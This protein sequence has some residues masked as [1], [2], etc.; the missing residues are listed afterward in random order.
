MRRRAIDD[1]GPNTQILREFGDRTDP[2][3]PGRCAGTRPRTARPIGSAPEVAARIR[4]HP[5]RV[6]QRGKCL[7]GLQIG[8]IAG[9]LTMTGAMSSSTPF[10]AASSSSGAVPAPPTVNHSEVAPF[11]RSST[12]DAAAAAGS[13]S[14]IG[15]RMSHPDSDRTMARPAGTAAS[16]R[17]STRRAADRSGVPSGGMDR[18]STVVLA[19][20]SQAAASGASS[21]SRPALRSTA[22][23][24]RSQSAAVAVAPPASRTGPAASSVSIGRS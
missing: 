10:S 22:A 4:R 5:A 14:V 8:D 11:S 6:E 12:A 17:E 1:Q 7:R 2:G 21:A 24:A 20:L 13:G 23:A 9:G 15:D 16:D 19:S 18:P 3:E